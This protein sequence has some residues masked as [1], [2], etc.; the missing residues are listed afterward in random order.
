MSVTGEP[1][2]GSAW[3][4]SQSPSSSSSSSSASDPSSTSTS[5]S[6]THTRITPSICANYS[7]FKR[8]LDQSRRA[9]DD[10]ITV[11]LNRAAALAGTVVSGRGS[12]REMGTTECDAVWREVVAR[13]DE[14]SKAL[15]YCDTALRHTQE[16]GRLARV[17]P[18]EEGL[19]R[20][21]SEEI[22]PVRGLSADWKEQG[23]GVMDE[24]ELKRS[25]LQTELSIERIIRARTLS[26]F[27]SRCPSHPQ[28]NPPVPELPILGGSENEDEER[29][30]RRGRDE[31]GRVRWN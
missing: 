21:R 3:L 12:A 19:D 18:Q 27:T 6:S 15:E 30:R 5:S 26:L 9:S 25:R 16:T 17:A 22:A 2:L 4:L 1:L 14:R 23:R 10:A 28:T 7:L 31:R 13:W 11:R 8:L 29:R 24:A 20:R